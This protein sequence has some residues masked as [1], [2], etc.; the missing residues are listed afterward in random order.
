MMLSRYVHEINSLYELDINDIRV[1]NS[2]L[3]QNAQEAA[4]II[5]DCALGSKDHFIFII[6]VIAKSS[7]IKKFGISFY[8]KATELDPLVS[9]SLCKLHYVEE[10][11]ISSCYISFAK[12]VVQDI[13]KLKSL[14][15]LAINIPHK[16]LDDAI[17]SL[18]QCKTL[19]KVKFR[20]EEF[21]VSKFLK[22]VI[23]QGDMK[24]ISLV[25]LHNLEYVTSEILGLLGEKHSSLETSADFCAAGTSAGST[26][27]AED[28]TRD[29]IVKMLD[30]E[31]TMLLT[32]LG[33]LRDLKNTILSADPKPS[34]VVSACAEEETHVT[35]GSTSSPDIDDIP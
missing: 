6:E 32:K 2:R 30:H 14:N 27:S 23:S 20:E 24:H 10:L 35:T 33:T 7:S 21:G 9:S 8:S 3:Y 28:S 5:L 1:Q 11:N 22:A 12:L 13:A 4:E 18:A 25:L 29:Q 26:S 31:E 19:R 17:S 34:S 15:T 16:D